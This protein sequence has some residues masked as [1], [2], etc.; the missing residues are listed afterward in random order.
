MRF[1][2]V[3][4][5]GELTAKL[6][7]A[8]SHDHL[9]H[10][11]LIHGRA[12]S[13]A[14]MLAKALGAILV[15]EHPTEMGDSCGKCAGCTKYDK[16]IHPDVTF[17]YPVA[18]AGDRD[19]QEPEIAHLA[20][21]RGYLGQ[22]TFP[23]LQSWGEYLGSLGK[24]FII[25]KNESRV[26]AKALSLKPFEASVKIIFLWLPEMIHVTAANR[27]LKLLEEPP[28]A[29]KIIMIAEALDS[30]LPTILSRT[31]ILHVPPYTESEVEQYLLSNKQAEAS[32]AEKIAAVTEGNMAEALHLLNHKGVDPAA[33][34]LDW[35]RAS[36]DVAFPQLNDLM[37]LFAEMNKEEQKG[38]FHHAFKL[39]RDSLV[40]RY[41][42]ESLLRVPDSR[43]EVIKRLSSK[44][45]LERCESCLTILNDAVYHIERNGNPRII[46][47]DTS[48]QLHQQLK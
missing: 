13:G 35:F 23:N 14:F 37:T 48:L 39:V 6:K 8:V 20:E 15:C 28:I 1:S 30:I 42:S 17:I 32:E 11:L 31:Q 34:A 10:A 21:W 36:R 45:P 16:F 47:L 27:L 3:Y 46:F 9:A 18:G 29:T 33:F 26:I 7:Q 2:N 25:S 43:K 40:L 41:G 24:A 12:G 44:L 38:M 19:S 4:E 22:N 5:L